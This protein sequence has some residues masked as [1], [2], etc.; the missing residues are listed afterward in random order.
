MPAKLYRYIT[1]GEYEMAMQTSLM[2]CKEC[3]CCS[4]VCP[5]HLSLV[6]TMKTGKKLGRKK[7]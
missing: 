3:G 6:H 7:K 1:N 2:D 5:A 4:F